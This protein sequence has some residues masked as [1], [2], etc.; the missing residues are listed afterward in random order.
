MTHALKTTQPFF[1]HIEEGK[2]TFEVRRNDR[3][4]KVG[5]K[6]LLQEFHNEKYTGQEWEGEITY[7]LDSTDFCKKGFVIL[8]IAE[9]S[10]SN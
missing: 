9:K 1:A 3:N 4:F 2:K 5:D 6:L 8:G 7:I 10:Q